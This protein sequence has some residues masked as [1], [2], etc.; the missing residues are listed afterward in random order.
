MYRIKQQRVFSDKSN[1]ILLN[2]MV[3]INQDT[4]HSYL[5]WSRHVAPISLFS[6]LGTIS[7]YRL[8][9]GEV[10]TRICRTTILLVICIGA[11][12]HL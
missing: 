7:S 1:A 11:K 3:E 5:W 10:K 2:I 6:D 12:R 9:S 8:L 4:C